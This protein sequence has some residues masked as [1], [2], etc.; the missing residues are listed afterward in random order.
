MKWPGLHLAHAP[1]AAHAAQFG[2]VHCWQ[3]ALALR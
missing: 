1:V 2:A 3:A